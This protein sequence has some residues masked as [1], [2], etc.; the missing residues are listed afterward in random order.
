VSPPP[1][2]QCGPC[3]VQ[4]FPFSGLPLRSSLRNLSPLFSPPV[5]KDL[6]FILLN[7]RYGRHSC[8][9]RK[10]ASVPGPG[11]PTLGEC[12]TPSLSPS[13]WVFSPPRLP[14]HAPWPIWCAFPRGWAVPLR[15]LPTRCGFLDS[16]SLLVSAFPPLP[17]TPLLVPTGNFPLA[18]FL[19][20]FASF[21]FKSFSVPKVRP[22]PVGFPS[23]VVLKRLH[24]PI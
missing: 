8:V 5:P 9:G 14:G 23:L 6:V 15:F 20:P 16:I 3:R 2:S 13:F 7:S 12:S 10:A 21:F 18:V 19:L 1:R 17:L 24:A 4:T 22:P 11:P